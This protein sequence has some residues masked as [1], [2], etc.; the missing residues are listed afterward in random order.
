MPIQPE[1]LNPEPIRWA[2]D[3]SSVWPD[4][5]D[6]AYVV[7]SKI[8]SDLDELD[9]DRVLTMLTARYGVVRGG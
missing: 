1:A 9:R 8:I 3:I 4:P 5:V 2:C 7:A 6:V